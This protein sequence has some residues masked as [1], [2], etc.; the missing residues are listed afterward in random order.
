MRTGPETYE[1][2]ADAD[3]ALVM[4]EAQIRSGEW[5]DPE[6]G[7]VKLG[8]YAAAWITERPGLRPARWT[9]TDGCSRKHIDA[10]PRRRAGREAVDPRDPGMAR[11]AAGQRRVRLGDGQGISA[12]PR[13]PDDRGGGRQAPPPQP[14]PHPR[15]RGRGRGRTA[16]PDRGPGLRAGRAGRAPPGRQHP[17]D[18]GRLPAPVRPQRRDAHLPEVYASRAEAER[19]LWKMAGDGR[20]DCPHDRRFCALVLLATFASLRWGEATALRRCDLDLD[21]GA[22]CGCGPPTSSG[23]PA[24]CSSGRRSPRPDAASSASPR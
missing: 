15:R 11:R 20:A 9:S 12:A 23:R 22:P 14:V 10:A 7:K 19:A 13:H 24:K 4:I 16:G 21:G 8:D 1:R 17:Q 3:R 5:T 6:R 2:K 18:P